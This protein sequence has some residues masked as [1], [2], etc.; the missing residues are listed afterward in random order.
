M[1][2]FESVLARVG[3]YVWDNESCIT[4]LCR[5]MVDFLKNK[6]IIV[7]LPGNFEDYVTV[8]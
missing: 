3:G 8:I 2:D 7:T 1:V 4:W 5:G 6:L